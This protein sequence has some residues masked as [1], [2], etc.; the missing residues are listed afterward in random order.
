MCVDYRALNSVTVK[1]RF[2]LPRIDDHIDKLGKYTFFNS[3]DM[4][5]GFHQVPSKDDASISKTAFVTPDGHFEYLKMPY[6]LANA[7]IVYQRIISKTLKPLMGA[8][9][10]VE[11]LGRL[12][13]NGQV[14]PSPGKVEALIK[15]PKPSSVKEVRQ[16]L[17]LAGYFRRYIAGYSSKT[18]C[19]AKLFRKGIP[20]EWGANQDDSRDYIIKCLTNEP[21][22]AIFDPELPMELHT[23]ASAV[24][25]GAILLQEHAD[26][27]SLKLTQRKKDLVPRVARWWVYLQDFQFTLEYRKG[28]LMQHAD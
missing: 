21:V 17:G 11:Y 22:L 15:S 7:P 14:R 10:E 19:I 12:I 3:L 26:C 2:P 20:F 28:V 4:A 8:G 27:N 6:G 9:T 13:G 1:E 25:L 16:F 24:G 18:A 5:T 23:D